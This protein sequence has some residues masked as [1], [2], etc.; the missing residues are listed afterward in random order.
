MDTAPDSMFLIGA[1]IRIIKLFDTMDDGKRRWWRVHKGCLKKLALYEAGEKL[2]TPLV[3]EAL[4]TQQDTYA[5]DA[6]YQ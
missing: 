4:I 2:E 6:Q 5:N 1:H 3:Y